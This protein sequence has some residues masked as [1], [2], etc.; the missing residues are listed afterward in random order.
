MT[1]IV[2]SSTVYAVDERTGDI[3]DLPQRT[4]KREVTK[5]KPYIPTPEDIAKELEFQENQSKKNEFDFKDWLECEMYHMTQSYRNALIKEIAE[6]KKVSSDLSKDLPIIME[7]L[8]E[9]ALPKIR[10]YEGGLS[11]EKQLKIYNEVKKPDFNK[12]FHETIK[13]NLC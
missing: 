9:I 7:A 6:A 8:K 12:I 5:R 11:K 1:T 3:I 10:A 4:G 13:N 2:T